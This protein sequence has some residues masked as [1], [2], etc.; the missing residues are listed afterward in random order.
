[1]SP[2]VKIIYVN[3]IKYKIKS[4]N[5]KNPNNTRIQDYINRKIKQNEKL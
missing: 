2:L 5:F 4:E 3:Y 1:M